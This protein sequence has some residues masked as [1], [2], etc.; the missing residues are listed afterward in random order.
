M[1][2][3]GKQITPASESTFGKLAARKT[4]AINVGRE[5]T[6]TLPLFIFQ[7]FQANQPQKSNNFLIVVS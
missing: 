1:E 6:C 2:A 7:L 5:D 3:E 4:T